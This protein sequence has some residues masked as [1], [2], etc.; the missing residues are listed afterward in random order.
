MSR[1]AARASSS[2][3]GCSRNAAPR[4]EL[5]AV[6]GP[7][8]RDPDRPP[9]PRPPRPLRP[10]SPLRPLRVRRPD[11]GHARDDRAR[12]HRP[13]RRGQHPGR[14]RRLQEKASRQ[15]GPDLGPT[16]RSRC[17]PSI[18]AGRPSLRFVS[19]LDYLE[20]VPVNASLTA[21]FF[22]AGHILG[23]SMI[24][25]RPSGEG[26]P[27][28]RSSSRATSAS[29]PSRSSTTPRFSPRPTT[30][31]WNRRTATATTRTPGRSRTSLAG[32]PSEAALRGG[33]VLIPVFALERA[34]EI[35]FYI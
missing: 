31:S 35:L 23:S 18:D 15:G 19:R 12:P 13:P 25:P 27:P 10:H 2:I 4:A 29:G 32:S 1:P 20:P 6:S 34:Q 22:D 24:D 26:R 30:W 17:I 9:D 8:R 11:P 7:A 14:R 3:A 5:G 16:P 28:L 33:N 21:R